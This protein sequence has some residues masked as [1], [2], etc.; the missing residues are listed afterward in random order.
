MYKS[1]QI[2]TQHERNYVTWNE[3]SVSRNMQCTAWKDWSVI[4]VVKVS[5][6]LNSTIFLFQSNKVPLPRLR[7]HS[8]LRIA[9]IITEYRIKVQ[10]ESVISEQVD[11]RC[12]NRNKNSKMRLKDILY[13][14]ILSL[15]VVVYCLSLCL[16]QYASL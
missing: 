13:S 3:Q 2:N 16:I 11:V 6:E 1:E 5:Y 4:Y 12:K 9:T 15:Q 10:A 14:K 8:H 7:L